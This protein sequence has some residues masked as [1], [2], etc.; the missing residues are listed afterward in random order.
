MSGMFL[1]LLLLSFGPVKLAAGH[2]E[3]TVAPPSTASY[4]EGCTLHVSCGSFGNSSRT[5]YVW[6]LVNH[7]W[8]A[9]IQFLHLRVSK[10]PFI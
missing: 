3:A 8:A 2:L 9:R 4:H 5:I 7:T 10:V 1:S 6:G